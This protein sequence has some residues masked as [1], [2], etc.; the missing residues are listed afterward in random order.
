[1]SRSVLASVP[2]L[3]VP[4]RNMRQSSKSAAKDPSRSGHKY[5][6]QSAPKGATARSRE[7]HRTD[8]LASCTTTARREKTFARFSAYPRE[9]SKRV[10]TPN[11][12]E[13]DD[14]EERRHM[15]F[16]KLSQKESNELVSRMYNAAG[17]TQR[18]VQEQ[19]AIEQL[20][21]DVEEVSRARF[22][23]HSVDSVRS[24]NSTKRRPPNW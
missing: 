1:M 22:T 10:T 6:A 19:R 16:R 4:L 8:C 5:R 24:G 17:K 23:L 7:K 13:R 18:R 2:R 12:R 3:V 15:S 9:Q 11:C 14:S 21:R 20:R